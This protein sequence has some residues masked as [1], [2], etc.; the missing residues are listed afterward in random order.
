MKKSLLQNRG[1]VLYPVALRCGVWGGLCAAT[2]G[3]VWVLFDQNSS[4]PATVVVGGLLI[5]TMGMMWADELEDS[6]DGS[7]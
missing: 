4:L 6:E 3:S 5:L 7:T 2:A 1:I